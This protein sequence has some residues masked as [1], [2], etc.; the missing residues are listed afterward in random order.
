MMEF[1]LHAFLK[2]DDVENLS[3]TEKKLSDLMLKG[4]KKKCDFNEKLI[5]R[6]NFAECWIT[7]KIKNRINLRYDSVDNRDL[8]NTVI[9]AK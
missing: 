5:K 6:D 9:A 1:E 2:N 3:K 4:W 8:Q 7:E